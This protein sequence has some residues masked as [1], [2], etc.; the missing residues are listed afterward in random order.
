[1]SQLSKRKTLDLVQSVILI[2]VGILIALSI[3]NPDQIVN[4]LCALIITVIG[5]YL[6]FKSVY[7]TKS[8]VSPGALAGGVL[9]GV[10]IAAFAN[11]INFGTLLLNILKVGILCVGILLTIQSV[12]L[13][14]QRRGGTV[15]PVLYLVIGIVAIIL[16]ILIL[17][18]II[19]NNPT[20]VIVGILL[21]VVGLV[22]LFA[23]LSKAAQ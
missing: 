6:L 5:C 22:N 1:M 9:V 12:V 10:G 20:Y 8:F 7:E 17:I 4:I 15:F 14:L 11:Y 3:I 13:L 19:P 18:N 16:G 21:A 2:V 23:V